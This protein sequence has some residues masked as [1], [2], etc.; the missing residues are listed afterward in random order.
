MEVVLRR[1][2]LGLFYAAI[3]LAIVPFG[4]VFPMPL[5][6]SVVLGAVALCLAGLVYV[7]AG[8]HA[9]WLVVAPLL[10]V[11]ASFAYVWWQTACGVP[12]GWGSDF[13]I[14]LEP[15]G[16]AQ[17]QPISAIGQASWQ[18]LPQLIAA[19]VLF[20]TG[21]ILFAHGEA[22]RP[23]DVLTWIGFGFAAVG[24][25][26]FLFF[27]DILL[28]VEKVA[29]RDSLTGFFVNRNTAGTFLGVAL[30]L[31]LL[32]SGRV[33]G[34]AA[35]VAMWQQML[36]VV[37]P[38]TI[39]VALMLTRSRASIACTGVA[40]TLFL[41]LHWWQLVEA[42]QR[43]VRLSRVEGR[44]IVAVIAA[45]AVFLLVAA[46]GPR[47]AQGV[48][49]D[50][51]LC[52]YASLLPAIADGWPFGHGLGSFQLTYPT[53]RPVECGIYG[54][55]ELAHNVYLEAAYTM[56]LFGCFFVLACLV[57]ALWMPVTQIW[58]R[59]RSQM[60]S[61]ALC[62]GILLCL[63]SAVDFSLQIPGMAAYTAAVMSTL[64]AILLRRGKDHE[65]FDDDDT[66]D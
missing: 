28:V 55:W 64:T 6:V 17:C 10:L 48:E 58:S 30:I 54:T 62:I 61:T 13:W 47:L 16:G 39:A 31:S 9:G 38:L 24:L 2:A 53:Y 50:P 25:V 33:I 41:V 4:A 59:S 44:I 15:L 60:A 56:G 20:A 7:P 42:A 63:H 23:L 36:A 37:I 12:A 66:L 35:D 40:L 19:P 22:T 26:N 57:G 18:I 45:L 49:D 34:G 27:P 5:Y 65:I 8:R 52:V 21:I 29:Y 1:M 43:L 3:V 11:A 32:T 46:A 14:L 51:R